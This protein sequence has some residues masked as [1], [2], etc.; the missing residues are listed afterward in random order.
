[1]KIIHP[2]FIRVWNK[3]KYKL[4]ITL[5]CGPVI[6]YIDFRLDNEQSQG[7]MPKKPKTSAKKSEESIA[8][9]DKKDESLALE[10]ESSPTEDQTEVM[11]PPKDPSPEPIYDEPVL[12]ELIIETYVWN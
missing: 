12:S 9:E 5:Y 11:D 8:E 3:L 10:T 2:K 1:M 7:K 6:V 4:S